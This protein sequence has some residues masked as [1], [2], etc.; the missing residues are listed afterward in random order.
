MTRGDNLFML[1][2]HPG[3][4]IFPVLRRI[5]RTNRGIFRLIRRTTT[6]AGEH[7]TKD[8]QQKPFGSPASHL[9]KQDV[10]E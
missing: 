8:K 7:D 5:P 3:Y 10:P 6:D 4:A 2:A 9:K 1:L